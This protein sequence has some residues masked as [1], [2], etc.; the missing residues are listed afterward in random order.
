[1]NF[2]ELDN[3]IQQQQ[4]LDE[5]LLGG[6]KQGFQQSYQGQRDKASSQQDTDAQ[7]QRYADKAMP[8][9]KKAATGA[10]HY[11]KKMG[12]PV[13]LAT[14]LVAS[15]IVGGPAAIPFAALMY[16]VRKPIMKGLSKTF[17]AGVQG[18]Q[19]LNQQQPAPAESVYFKDFVYNEGIMDTIGTGIGKAA[20]AVS[21]KMANVTQKAA[22]VLKSGWNALSQ[23][24]SQNKLAIGKAAF[25]M[26]AG[27]LIG[28]GIG[29]A[30]KEL[31]QQAVDAMVAGGV[32]EGDPTVAWLEKNF[33]LE[34]SHGDDSTMVHGT[35]HM[36]NT[37][38]TQADFDQAGKDAFQ[39]GTHNDSFTQVDDAMTQAGN[40][41]A[42]NT[43]TIEFI[44][45][46]I[47]QTGRDTGVL[48]YT[49]TL[50]AQPGLSDDELIKQAYQNISQSLQQNG[51]TLQDLQKMSGT[52]DTGIQVVAKV[53]PN[54]TGAGAVGGAAAMAASQAQQQPQQQQP[55]QQ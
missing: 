14:A 2:Y 25:M 28:A 13:P 46:T 54:L 43:S 5:G 3:F 29:Y 19:N 9:I 42:G 44:R 8:A 18:I 48:D 20:G 41:A 39:Y 31:A 36:Q 15:G 23:F 37:P 45:Q 7:M 55:Q 27:A 53:I 30:T 32:P 22:Q 4:V 16:F 49:A 52:S 51:V 11:A 34:V 38:E 21:G 47:P 50:A 17:D 6:I 40:A 33:N 12:I 24:A 35:Q 1:M 10:Q 26:S